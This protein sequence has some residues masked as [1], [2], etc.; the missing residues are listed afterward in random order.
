MRI[1]EKRP[2]KRKEK[3][4]LFVTYSIYERLQAKTKEI[5]YKIERKLDVDK[6][7][8]PTSWQCHGNDEY[9][10]YLFVIESHSESIELMLFFPWTKIMNK[11][12]RMTMRKLAGMI[13]FGREGCLYE[14]LLSKYISEILI[15]RRKISH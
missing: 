4:K 3:D 2:R 15:H 8:L 12:E 14:H 1:Y 11:K 7:E 9:V 10:K 6:T 5:F 13:Q